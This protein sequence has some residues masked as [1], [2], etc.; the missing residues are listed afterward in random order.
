MRTLHNANKLAALKIFCLCLIGLCAPTIQAQRATNARAITVVTEPKA[1]V[2]LDDLM[3]GTTDAGGRLI[4]KPV[5]PGAHKIRVRADGFKEVSQPVTAAQAGE[6]KIALTKTEDA[7]E[8]AFQEAERL[9]TSD[10]EKA[11]AAYRKAI[12][13]R[14]KYAEAYVAL[15]RVMSASGDNEGA[16]KAVADARRARAAY[17]EASAVEGRIYAADGE[18]EKALA[19]FK[20]AITEGRGIQPEAHTG[21]GLIY[22][23]K[24]EAAGGAGDFEAEA[25]NYMLA[26]ASFKKAIAQLGGALDAITI[27]QFVG[28]AY[29]RMKKFPEAIAVY[30]EFLRVFPDANEATSVQSFIVQIKK[31]M[32]EQ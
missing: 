3:R 14:P 31:Q 4:V 29:E 8:L 5:M 30:E 9:T 2:W 26:V 19:A 17:A 6:I 32:S 18:E 15:A 11:I 24:A 28:L 21:I 20:R 27:Y 16:L 13:A 1:I 7:A 22:K 10:R 25:E 12:A 23:E